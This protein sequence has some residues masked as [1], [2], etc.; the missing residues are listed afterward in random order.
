MG[1]QLSL[2]KGP[3][4]LEFEILKFGLCTACGACLGLCPYFRVRKEKVSS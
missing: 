1:Y 3:A 4:E 2:H